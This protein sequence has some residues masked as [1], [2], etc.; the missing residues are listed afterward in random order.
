MSEERVFTLDQETMEMFAS[1]GIQ[2]GS[3]SQKGNA[4][5]LKVRRVMQLIRDLACG[6][7][8]YAIEAGR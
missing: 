2:S 4:N 7:G 8:V 5:G 1:K 6:E 3:A